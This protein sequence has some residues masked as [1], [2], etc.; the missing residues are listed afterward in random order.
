MYTVTIYFWYDMTI[1]SIR[2]LKSCHP[3]EKLFVQH[4]KHQNSQTLHLEF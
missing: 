1:S 2:F 3:I 4:F